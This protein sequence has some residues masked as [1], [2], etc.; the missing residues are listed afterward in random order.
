MRVEGKVAFVSGG[1][2]GLGAADVCLLSQEGAAVAFGDVLE[3]EGRKLEAELRAMGRR[4]MFVPLDVTDEAQ[5]VRAVAA[6][7]E[8]FGGFGRHGKQRR[9]GRGGKHRE[10]TVEGWN[11]VMAVNVTGVFLGTRVVI[12]E[13][14]KRGGGSI[15]NISSQMGMVGSEM[16]NVAYQTL[17]GSGCGCSPRRR[18][19]ITPRT[20][21]RVNSVHPGPILTR[22]MELALEENR[23][24]ESYYLDRV[25]LGRLGRP[26]DVAYC[27]LYLASDESAFVTGSEQVVDGGWTAQ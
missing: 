18:R 19:C 6:T 15:I 10:T 7:V 4:V 12:P 24:Q 22:Q 3:E 1:A 14:R 5:W 17:Q 27:V 25:P 21:I 13:M 23:R 16:S 9:S 26:L 11:R 2:R 20:Q 8:A